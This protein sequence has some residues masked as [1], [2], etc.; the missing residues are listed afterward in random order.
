M[1]VLEN[2]GVNLACIRYNIYWSVSAISRD[3][4]DRL[5]KYHYTFMRQRSNVLNQIHFS[6]P[7]D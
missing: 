5:I 6:S 7:F 3:C 1:M 4:L 2:P